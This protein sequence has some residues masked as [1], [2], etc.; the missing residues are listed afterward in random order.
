MS[1][2][3]SSLQITELHLRSQAKELKLKVL[4]LHLWLPSPSPT[5]LPKEIFQ[6]SWQPPD[7]LA[8]SCP[9]HPREGLMVRGSDRIDIQIIMESKDTEMWKTLLQYCERGEEASM[10][11]RVDAN[12]RP[13]PSSCW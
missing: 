4:L 2:L 9:S 5:V 7:L 6:L 8:E 12:S 11:P 3:F 1:V 10:D 13:G